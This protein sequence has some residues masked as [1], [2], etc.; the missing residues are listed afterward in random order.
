MTEKEIKQLLKE[1]KRKESLIED[2][3]EGGSSGK[4]IEDFKDLW[5]W[6]NR[7]SHN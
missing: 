3:P 2:D 4:D 7:Q 5:K 1:I 6:K